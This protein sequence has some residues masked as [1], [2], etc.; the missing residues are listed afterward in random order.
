[1]Q[2]LELVI[3]FIVVAVLLFDVF[4]TVVLPRP[5]PATLRPS[6][7]LVWV[8]YSLSRWVALRLPAERREQVL[9]T[10]APLSVMVQL[11]WWVVA[12]NV[13][14]GLVL[15]GLAHEMQPPLTGFGSALYFSA[16]SML[17][18][19][20]GDITPVGGLARLLVLSEAGTGLGLVALIIT[21]LFTLFGAFQR[22]EVLVITLSMRAGAP[23]SGVSLLETYA[24]YDM[25]GDLPRLF[26]DWEV[27]S[28]EVLDS[29]LSYPI[30]AYFRSTHDNQSWISALG[31][32]L[33]AGTLL[34][35]V[36]EGG[37]RG[38]A[39]LM[40]G[41]GIHLVEDLAQYFRLNGG[42]DV[43]V[44]REEFDA[45]RER[46]AAAGFRLAPEEASWKMFSKLR[47]DYA[48][49]LNAM[50][51]LWVTPPAQWIGDRPAIVRHS[52][53]AARMMRR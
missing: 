27:W 35:T 25:L 32:V 9:G 7:G 23:P 45:A 42:Q 37:P 29:H 50:A 6:A 38:P 26:A 8:L 53:F 13:G 18:L 14:F 48:A 11:L 34:L 20:Y 46:L 28:A 43:Y 4:Q 51:R 10:I 1:V 44:E 41:A 15:L 17:T 39:K 31:A 2:V 21:F 52:G 30:L 36:V 3:G 22:R 16:V 33:D 40:L 5:T 12:L 19:G 47:A 24:K 49:S